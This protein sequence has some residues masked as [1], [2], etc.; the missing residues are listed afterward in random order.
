MLATVVPLQEAFARCIPPFDRCEPPSPELLDM[1]GIPLTDIVPGRVVLIQD[2]IVN[3]QN[4]TQPFTLLV[5]IK[6]QYDTVISLSWVTGELFERQSLK[7]SRSWI[8]DSSGNF[9]VEIFIWESISRP[10]PLGPT[11]I[12][13]VSV[14]PLV[15]IVGGSVNPEQ[16]D[17][18][19]PR[20]IKVVLGVNN[21]VVW[22]NEDSVAHSVV[23]DQREFDSGLMQPSQNWSYTFT[24]SGEYRYHSVPHPWM[25]GTVIV[26]EE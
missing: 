15:R 20:V 23:S 11:K 8:P 7:V 6:D 9:T 16:V 2:E 24:K 13:A 12:I 4:K 21:T 5:Q 18:Y 10:N 26:S 25:K 19:S 17:N 3:G 14:F 22:L 1:D